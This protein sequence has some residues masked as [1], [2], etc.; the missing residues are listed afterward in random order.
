MIKPNF[1][2]IWRYLWVRLLV[3]WLVIAILPAMWRWTGRMLRWDLLDTQFNSLVLASVGVL[4]TTF[5]LNRLSQFPGQRSFSH[6]LPT[7]LVVVM[8]LGSVLLIFRLPYSLYYLAFASVFGLLFFLVS[9]LL[10]QKISEPFMAYIPLG[11]CQNFENTINI[12]WL[13]L[14]NPRLDTATAK[15]IDGIVADLASPELNDEWQRFLT[16]Q[17]LQGVPVYNQQQMYESLTGRSPIQHLYENDLGSLL[18]SQNYL[19]IKQLLDNLA[20]VLVSPLVVPICLLT[21]IAIR[22]ESSG[23]AIFVQE[24]VGQGGKLFKIYKFRSMTTDAEK[25]GAKLAQQND[26]RVTKVGKFIRKTRIDELPQF[27]NVLK[28]EMSLIGPRPEQLSFVKQFEQKI[29]FYNYRHIVKPGISGWAQVTQG[30][31]GNED[32][33]ALKIQYDFFYI[34]NVSLALDLLIVIKT[35]QTMLTG[36]GAR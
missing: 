1:W 18:P 27:I 5:A 7:L 14:E 2:G 4:L 29:P 6:V 21:A 16:E 26:A 15:R 25:H 11:R 35:V 23:K 30:Y 32:E 12:K 9:Y 8:L 3:G 31:A 20:V 28:G 22:L 36:F 10:E 13:R 33:T 19:I 34:K 17:T 24:R